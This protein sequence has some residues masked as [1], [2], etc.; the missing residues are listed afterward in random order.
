MS[1]DLF[2][3]HGQ[4]LVRADGRIAV[5]EFVGPWNVE[6]VKQWGHAITSIAQ[7]LSAL[8][9]Y[10]SLTKISSTAAISPESLSLLR[11][12]TA[13]AQAHGL[14]ATAL[15]I[16]PDVEGAVFARSMYAPAFDGVIPFRIFETIDEGREWVLA[17]LE[18]AQGQ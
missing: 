4:F 3:P 12:I 13:L 16:A 5:S 18:P 14:V 8:G 6:L 10:V 9:P 11:K 1:F 2:R 17:Q 15:V 7:Q